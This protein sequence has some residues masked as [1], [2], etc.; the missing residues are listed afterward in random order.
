[1]A[2][3]YGQLIQRAID[4]AVA[5]TDA[6]N[7]PIIKQR[8][9]TESLVDLALQAVA[10]MVAGNPQLRARLEKQFS[11]ALSS[12]VGT[13]P[14]QIMLEYLR[15]GAVRDSDTSANNGLGNFLAKVNR[16]DQFV[17]DQSTALGLYCVVDNAIYAR[18]PGATDPAS[19]IGPLVIDAPFVPIT[20]DLSTL[21]DD[22]IVNDL[23]EDLAARLRGLLV[24]QSEAV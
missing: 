24:P 23:L 6:D 22:E 13:M 8:L 19:T 20:T 10:S 17:T 4:I 2:I 3:T 21:V 5:G 12:G 15:E 11:V 14:A 16:Y 9:E 18:P 7:N 1:M